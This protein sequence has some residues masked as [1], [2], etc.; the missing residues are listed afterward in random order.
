MTSITGDYL[1]HIIERCINTTIYLRRNVTVER[2]T[3]ETMAV[4]N[5][6]IVDF[7]VSI[8][9]FDTK[10]KDFIV[11]N[12]F[13]QTIISQAW[14]NQFIKKCIA[15]ATDEIWLQ[16]NIPVLKHIH[17]VEINNNA[18]TLPY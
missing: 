1:V 12:D 13:D 10:L 8:P 11:G 16:N 18:L 17:N 7:I 9:Y 4:T 3:L 6:E 5:E 2:L 14:E 15:W